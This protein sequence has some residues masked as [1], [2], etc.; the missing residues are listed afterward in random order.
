MGAK[1]CFEIFNEFRL[2]YCFNFMGQECG[3]IVPMLATFL[4]SVLH[5]LRRYFVPLPWRFLTQPELQQG[6]D[7][8][9]CN[10]KHFLMWY[11]IKINCIYINEQV[12]SIFSGNLRSDSEL[13]RHLGPAFS[14]TPAKRTLFLAAQNFQPAA[15]NFEPAAQNFEPVARNF[16]PVARN[17]VP[18]H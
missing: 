16:K 2:L 18:A 11:A 12:A 10:Q 17:F 7:R 4:C 13:E 1:C 9:N 6:S 3:G 5:L 14:V 8:L 15:R